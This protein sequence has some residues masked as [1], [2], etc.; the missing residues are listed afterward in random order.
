MRGKHIYDAFAALEKIN[1]KGYKFM[2]TVLVNARN[3]ALH[4]GAHE[5]CLFVKEI[6]LGKAVRFK[7]IDIRAKGKTGVR[8]TPSS[9]IR[10]VLEEKSLEDVYKLNISGHCP[11]G[12]AAATR[13][14]LLESS[15]DFEQ[16]A[17]VAHITTARGRCEQRKRFRLRLEEVH[18]KMCEHFGRRLA[19]RVTRKVYME[20]IASEYAE[21][22]R[23]KEREDVEERKKQRE[24]VYKMNYTSASIK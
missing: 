9:S 14:A 10:M 19:R 24:S 8:K 7:R 16:V 13:K 18:R 15:A 1:K 2:F 20:R 6:V 4:K 12:L 3:N 11:P 23:R 21:G 22:I 17:K 5:H